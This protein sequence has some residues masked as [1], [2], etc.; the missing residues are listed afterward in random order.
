M[1]NARTILLWG[2]VLIASACAE[3]DFRGNTQKIPAQK[4]KPPGPITKTIDLKCSDSLLTQQSAAA[5]DSSGLEAKFEGAREIV[6]D[7][8]AGQQVNVKING[9]FCPKRS[10]ET[11]L[12]FVVDFS[13]SMGRHVSSSDGDEKPG[14]DP[15]VN[16]SCGRLSAASAIM[17]KVEN[18]L[19]Y[20][21]SVR[22][23]FIPFAGDVL[24]DRMVQPL[25]LEIFKEDLNK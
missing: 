21:D 25:E 10:N 17:E 13:G 7:A 4:I 19:Q 20:G 15:Q 6:I 5:F 18:E 9:E 1:L 22:V 14:N 23:G 8:T 24:S 2:G 11:T 12:L 3:A 16:D